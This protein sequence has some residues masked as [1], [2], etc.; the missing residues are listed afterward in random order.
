M[1]ETPQAPEPAQRER[2]GIQEAR[3]EGTLKL[4]ADLL[5]C[6]FQLPPAPS[7]PVPQPRSPRP[8][9]A[10]RG[11]WGKDWPG[12]P[13][14]SRGRPTVPAPILGVGPLVLGLVQAFWPGVGGGEAYLP[15]PQ[16]FLG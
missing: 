11:A 13:L 1:R 8:Q 2:R 10:P 4:C 6:D 3:G 14:P 5:D 7:P 15:H 12:A 9:A 16:R